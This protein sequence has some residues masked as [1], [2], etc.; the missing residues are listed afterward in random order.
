MGI[1][2]KS[3]IWK[4]AMMQSRSNFRRVACCS[5][6]RHPPWPNYKK[7][8]KTGLSS[9]SPSPHVGAIP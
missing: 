9:P 4:F 1:I 7:C 5:R 8:R 6:C 2:K 3:F